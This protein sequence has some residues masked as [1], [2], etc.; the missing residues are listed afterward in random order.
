MKKLL[1]L[2]FSII[3]I[4]C[5]S[6]SSKSESGKSTGESGIKDDVVTVDESLLTGIFST[7]TH[8]G[9]DVQEALNH[10]KEGGTYFASCT[11]GLKQNIKTFRNKEQYKSYFLLKYGFPDNEK[12]KAVYEKGWSLYLEAFD[13]ELERTKKVKEK[14]DAL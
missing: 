11:G 8:R 10:I 14:Y 9:I 1:I 13:A 4:F 2:T 12:A 6:C 7:E 5:G 3:A